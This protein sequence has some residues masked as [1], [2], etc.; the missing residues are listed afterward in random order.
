M[1]ERSSASE[2]VVIAGDTQGS[3][4]SAGSATSLELAHTSTSASFR[5]AETNKAL[6][7]AARA[8]SKQKVLSTKP[9]EHTHQP[10]L[11]L[12]L[13]EI[14][15]DM[16]SMPNALARGA[17]FNAAKASDQRQYHEDKPVASLSNIKVIYRGQELRQDDC[18]VLIA[19]L[20]FQRE[21]PIGEPVDFTAYQM[22]KEL[23][24]SHN[25][26]EY[27]HLRE[28]CDRLS[29]TN[30]KVYT[31]NAKGETTGFAGSLLRNFAWKD[32]EDKGLSRWKVTFE[33]KIANF[34]KGDDFSI[35]DPEIR[36]KLTGR[37]PL[38]QWLH[39]FLNSHAEPLPITVEKY[40]EL[41]ESRS[42]NL[43]EFRQRLKVALQRLK[44]N[45]FLVDFWI[46]KRDD[47]VHVIRER[48]KHK[49]PVQRI[50]P[51]PEEVEE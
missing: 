9:V 48:V 5:T 20:Y 15:Q 28:C 27:N 13:P 38:A 22:L 3:D 16:R 42:K 41:T 37:A 51:K 25:K 46:D 40:M 29:A 35:I 21:K 19:L 7:I 23:G 17:L 47:K 44:E 4:T 18:S 39:N 33:P 10:E 12:F 36:R 32:D 31:T 2:D 45:N 43:A 24:W 1:S 11:P 14:E 8:K 50:A 34:F 49:R 26:I 30:L 6:D